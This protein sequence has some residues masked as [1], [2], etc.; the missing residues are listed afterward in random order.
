MHPEPVG[1]DAGF[2]G[3][4]SLRH[5]TAQE[6]GSIVA[7]AVALFRGAPPD[8]RL[9][10]DR[11]VG[12]WFLMTSTRTRIAFSAAAAR[13]GGTPLSFGSRELQ[14]ATG[15]TIEDTARV[16]GSMLDGLVIRS[17]MH[18]T[19]LESLSAHAGIPVVNAMSTDEHPTQG[20]CDIAT[21][22]LHLGPLAGRQVLYVGEGNNTASALVLAAA[23][24]PRLQ[25]FLVVPPG[26][27]LPDALID[28]CHDA[29]SGLGGS[30]L[31]SYDFAQAPPHCDAVYTTRW[32][33]TG[34]S[35]PD[36]DW[37]RI[38]APYQVSADL[39]RRF[40]A[41]VFMHD[42]PAHR[43]EEVTPEVI[44]GP[45]SICWDQARM[46]HYSAIAVLEQVFRGGGRI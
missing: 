16:M 12:I 23:R 4:T 14:I 30:V 7:R 15:E 6:V 41:A 22:L 21:L 25:V 34:T 36:P 39:M 46:K 40:P 29:A 31:Q 13:L 26:Y 10:A 17:G 38:F 28:E 45:R 3:L 35:K 24:V 2:H 18:S 43:G 37:R 1:T 8:R 27:G 42:L 33:T 11:C 9:L 5:L 20:L 44:D 32:Q 19:E